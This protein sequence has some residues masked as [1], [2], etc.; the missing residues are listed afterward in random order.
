MAGENIEE[1]EMDVEKSALEMDKQIEEKIKIT[2]H[3]NG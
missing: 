3:N 2:A 1:I